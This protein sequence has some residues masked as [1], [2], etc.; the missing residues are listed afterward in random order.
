MQHDQNDPLI[1]TLKRVRRRLAFQ[2]AVRYGLHG[3]WIGATVALAS[4]VASRLFTVL[5]DPAPVAASVFGI[6]VAGGVALAL[7]HRPSLLETA[8]E[9]DR[10]LQSRER[11]T[12]SRE[13]SGVEGSMVQAVHTDARRLLESRDAAEQFGFVTPRVAKW[14]PVP[15]LLFGL[16][17]LFLPEF[18]LLNHNQRTVEARLQ[19]EAAAVRVERLKQAARPLADAALA[20]EGEL[21]E[22]LSELENLTND[23]ES[24]AINEKQALARI[25]NLADKLREH[26]QSLAASSPELSVNANQAK[27]SVTRELANALQEGRMGEAAQKAAEIQKKLAAA[28]SEEEKKKLREDLEALADS[29]QES[30][31]ALGQAL[32]KTM[33]DASTAMQNGQTDQAQASLEEML[34]EL[35]DAQSVMDQLNQMDTSMQQ[36][37]EWQSDN[38]GPSD[39]CRQCGTDLGEC[40]HSG[41]GECN[42]AGHKHSGYCEACANGNGWGNGRGLGMGGAGQGEGNSVGELPEVEVGLVPTK[43]QGR[44]SKGKMLA[45]ILQRSAPDAGQQPTV[46]SLEGAFVEMQQEA[47]QAL[48]KE[49]IPPASKEYVRQ[50]FGS[51][52][53]E[54]S[55][56]NQ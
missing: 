49:V 30:D 40:D 29:L 20:A 36:L 35:Q 3:V 14:A 56:P 39:Y 55:D 32:A 19:D 52:E 13:L 51:L 24:G 11:I 38:L 9:A 1:R 54:A 7:A 17:Y 12:S 33:T 48:V 46:E 44:I 26:R 18:D 37:A 2:L 43:A 42:Q 22:A 50:Y 31:S 10:R 34:K 47:E 5:G 28:S 4:V 23:L 6:A 25:G 21:A 15:L 27:L 41:G 16:A 45:E 53:P 8:L